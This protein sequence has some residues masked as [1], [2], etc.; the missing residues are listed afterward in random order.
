MFG[1][2]RIASPSPLE[3]GSGFEGVAAYICAM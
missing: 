1:D 3:A 2:R